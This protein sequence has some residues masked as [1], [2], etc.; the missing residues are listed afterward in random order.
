MNKIKSIFICSECGH[1]QLKWTGKC[2]E[3]GQWNTLTEQLT[4]TISEDKHRPELPLQIEQPI[5]LADDIKHFSKT[6]L[7]KPRITTGFGELDRVLGGGLVEGATILLGGAPGIGKSTLMLQSADKIGKHNNQRVMYITSEESTYQV[8]L[9][10]NRLKLKGQNIFIDAQTNLEIILNHIR[11]YKP[12]IVIIDSIQLIYKPNLPATPGG[13][14]QLKQCG[15]ELVW[16]AKSNNITVIMVGHITKQGAIAGPKILEHI[17]DI[18]LYFEGDQ[19][20][21]HRIIRASKNR[22]GP[23]NEI[24]IFQM[25]NNGLIEI[26][27]PTGLFT[28]ENFPNKPGVSILASAEGSR[29]LFLE[30]QALTTPG[31]PGAIKRKT[32]GISPNRTN[33]IIA[34]LEKHLKL[35]LTTRDI[36]V[37]AVGGLKVREPAGDLAIGLAIA[38][39]YLDKSLPPKTTVFGEV[40][41]TSEIRPTT[42]QD[43]RIAE[44]IRMGFEHILIPKTNAI[45]KPTVEKNSK[46]I[47][48]NYLQQAI[49]MLK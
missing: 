23:T 7:E 43:K 3:C 31:I 16:L 18:V 36:F 35:K 17:V 8:K 6:T 12:T 2:P 45:S 47:P 25:S 1:K 11:K 41:L 14:G 44:A 22:F 38:G 30:I 34:V 10:A 5:H 37:N 24:G 48:I 49:E 42:E 4:E 15:T 9:R 13:V 29:I 26:K 28:Q 27:D 19:Y 21:S 20:H 33:M 40:G 32:T 46:I 39:A